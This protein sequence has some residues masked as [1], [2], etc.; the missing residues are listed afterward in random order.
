ML[1]N[2]SIMNIHFLYTIASNDLIANETQISEELMIMRLTVRQA[3]L[4]VVSMTQE[5]FLT[6]GA[7][8]MLHMPVLTQ[9]C[10]HALLNRSTTGATNGNAHFVVAPQTIQ[11]ILFKL[12]EIK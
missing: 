11:F 7:H 6:L 5:G 3:A 10:D 4:L 1:V 9:R 12:K 2:F 8:E